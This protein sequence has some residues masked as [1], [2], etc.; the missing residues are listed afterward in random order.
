MLPES[1]IFTDELRSYI[2]LAGHFTAHHRIRH[3]SHIYV[4]G[5]VHTN[6]IEGFFGHVKNGLRGTYHSVSQK[7]LQS[8]LNEYV[9]RY[10]ERSNPK[11]MFTTLIERAAA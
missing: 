11:A 2:G 3:K 5:N 10:N 1:T 8:Y 7:W 4:S 9:F 6:T